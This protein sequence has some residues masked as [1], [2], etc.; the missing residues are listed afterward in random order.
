M[1]VEAVQ[2]FLLSWMRALTI[3]GVAIIAAI[4]VRLVVP[5]FIRR[6]RWLRERSLHEVV[7]D[8]LIRPLYVSIILVGVLLTLPLFDR[9]QQVFLVGAGVLSLLT[10]IW[11]RTGIRLVSR[12]FRVLR[13]QGQE[14]E[15]APVLKNLWTFFLLVVAFLFLL[16]VWG[17]DVTP[18]LAGA[19]I[20]GIII[21]IAAQD[22]IANFFAGISLN[23]DQ[24]Y[25]IGD[26]LQL[27][28]GT[29]GTVTEISIRSTTVLT[30]DNIEIT[31]PNSYL[32]N[33]Q[34]INESS[35]RRRRRLRLDVGVA[36]GSDLHHVEETLIRVAEDTDRILDTPS[37]A[38]KYRSFEDSAILAQL[39]CHIAHPAQRGKA[40]HEL[41]KGISA[42][43][44]D[45]DIKIPFPQREMTFFEAGNEIQVSERVDHDSD[46]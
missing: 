9:P 5:V 32:N 24:T 30:R 2:E 25:K 29:R 11:V 18:L 3:I 26:M 37:P 1:P 31:I 6:S 46:S 42:A 43:F 41:I 38:V 8:E 22:T 10:I 36:Y 19:G 27:E 14:P 28:D 4:A 7:T 23:L 17:I 34:V 40:R 16:N 39:Q 12:S 21:G 45:E 33:T 15:F 44:E 35:P 13:E 20:A